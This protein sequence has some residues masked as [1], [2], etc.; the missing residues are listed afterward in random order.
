MRPPSSLMS[1]LVAASAAK[2]KRRH[3]SRK[4]ECRQGKFL[5]VSLSISAA[6][7]GLHHAAG[8]LG[9]Q[10]FEPDAVDH[11]DRVEHVALGFRHLLTLG[12]AHQAMDVDFVERDI[13]HELQAHHDHAGHP[14]D[15]VETGDQHAGRIELLQ[16]IGL[17][18]PA[19]RVENGHSAELNQVSSV[20]VLL[21]DIVRGQVVFVR[22]SCSERPT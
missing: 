1:R 19:Q 20:L 12:V 22:T 10:V 21:Q 13:V 15:D 3:R 2:V 9:D 4:P 6:P 7:A 5:R 8:A 11:V 16:A 18:G 14:K 17:L